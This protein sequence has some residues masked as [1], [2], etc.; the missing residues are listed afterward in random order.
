M[1][2]PRG[3]PLLLLLA[4]VGCRIERLSPGRADSVPIGAIESGRGGVVD[5]ARELL[6]LR[7]VVYRAVDLAAAREWYTEWIGAGPY[8]DEPFYL[9]FD[10]GGFELGITP[11]ED[12]ITRGESGTAYWGVTNADSAW[13]RLLKLGAKP[14]EPLAD[15]GD[16]VRIGSVV[17]P[18]GNIIGIV[19]NPHFKIER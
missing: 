5:S 17:D 6:G 8:F 11:A 4:I 10:V 13:R 16:G 19:T 1:R 18:F 9:G 7:T 15:V 3:A 14:H 2:R 12:T